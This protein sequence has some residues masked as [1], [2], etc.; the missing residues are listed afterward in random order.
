MAMQPLSAPPVRVQSFPIYDT[1]RLSGAT[2]SAQTLIFFQNGLGANADGFTSAPYKTLAETN[3]S[4]RG[5]PNGQ[6]YRVDRVGVMARVAEQSAAAAA[7]DSAKQ[8]CDVSNILRN[9]VLQYQAGAE[10]V[11]YGPASFFPGGGGVV[12]AAAP[13][14]GATTEFGQIAPQNGVQSHEAIWR[15]SEKL[16]LRDGQSF[17][18][19]LKQTR[20]IST[21][22]SSAKYDLSICLWGVSFQEVQG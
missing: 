4:G 9:C 14:G 18:F 3:L 7:M 19:N 6:A 21:Q 8:L 17:F 16:I 5:L 10:L 13:A 15:L 12:S 20:D 2:L 11:T 1:H 22:D